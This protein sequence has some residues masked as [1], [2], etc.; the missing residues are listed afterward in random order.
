MKYFKNTELAK[1]Y[2]VSEKSVRNWIQSAQ[3][4]KLALQLYEN[5]GRKH[6]ANTTKNTNLIEELAEKGKKFKNSRGHKTLEP[7]PK[8][9]ELY[10]PEQIIDIMSSIDIHKE[11][12][13]QYTYFNSGAKRWDNLTH[14]LFSGEPP[15]LVVSTI[16]LLDLNLDY[17]DTLLED[18]QGVNII[19]VGIGNALPMRKVIDHF[20][21]KGL[22]KRYIGIDISKEMLEIAE[23]NIQDWFGGSVEFEGHIRDVTYQRFDDLLMAESF[24]PTRTVNIVFLLGGT[25]SNFRDPNRVLAMLHDSI[26][27]EDLLISSQKPDTEKARRYFDVTAPGNLEFDLVVR[28]LN[29]DNS[30]YTLEQFFD[31]KSMSRQVRMKLKVAI[32]IKIQVSG[33]E[34]VLEF[35]KGD[36]I[37][38]LRMRHQSAI[39]MIG[40][41]NQNGFD[42]MQ[43]THTKGQGYLLLVSKIK[44]DPDH[45]R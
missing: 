45:F 2:H 10:S 39:D 44:S 15:N 38:L 4:G 36:S 11:I 30:L 8:F 9:Y 13:I 20:H 5:N 43:A 42:L 7:L 19:D 12:P 28:L 32:T 29:I 37:L 23:S 21:R 25:F 6:V 1:L 14:Q 27:K 41:L 16:Q 26:G 33:Q 18:Y 24:A 3:E 40:Q 17:I 34:R 31:E 22:L 35:N